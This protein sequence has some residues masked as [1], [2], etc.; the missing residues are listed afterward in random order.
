MK[1]IFF[2][3][4]LALPAIVFANFGGDYAGGWGMMGGGGNIFMSLAFVVWL[5]VGVLAAVWLWQHIDRK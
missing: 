2:A 4:L 3:S 1:K 5:V